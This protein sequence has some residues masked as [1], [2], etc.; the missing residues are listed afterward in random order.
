MSILCLVGYICLSYCRAVGAGGEGGRPPPNN[1]RID[2]TQTK[3][4]TIILFNVVCNISSARSKFTSKFTGYRIYRY[5]INYEIFFS[6]SLKKMV[7][8]TT[9]GR[10]PDQL[11]LATALY[12]HRDH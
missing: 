12:W 5:R 9:A 8:T 2:K 10:P 3:Y 1:L 7:S 4:Y 11:C 6:D